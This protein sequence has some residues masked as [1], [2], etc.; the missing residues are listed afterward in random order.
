MSEFRCDLETFF[1][2]IACQRFSPFDVTA[3]CKN[4]SGF[5]FLI[6]NTAFSLHTLIFS[7]RILT[8]HMILHCGDILKYNNYIFRAMFCVV[9]YYDLAADVLAENAHLTFKYLTPVSYP[10]LFR[11]T[12]KSRPNNIRGEKNVRPYVRPYVRTSVLPSVR[13]QKVS[14]IS[15]KFGYR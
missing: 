3:L 6:L 12:S 8:G 9:Q 11:S 10:S 5:G 13:P 1:L 15:M 2:R 7:L 14:S 4:Y